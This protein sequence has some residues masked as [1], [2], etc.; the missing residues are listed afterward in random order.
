MARYNTKAQ[1]AF[2]Q[3]VRLAIVRVDPSGYRAHT[4][5]GIIRIDTATKEVVGMLKMTRHSARRSRGPEADGWEDGLKRGR[6][7][8]CGSKA[9]ALRLAKQQA[10]ELSLA[11]NPE[12]DVYTYDDFFKAAPI[13]CVVC[14]K[15]VGYAHKV[16]PVPNALCE[17]CEADATFGKARRAELEQVDV[18]YRN[19]VPMTVGLMDR[20]REDIGGRIL[21]S[22]ECLILS[23]RLST[24]DTHNKR[25]EH[26]VRADRGGGVTGRVVL[27]SQV[28]RE[29]LQRM[30]DTLSEVVEAAYRSGVEHGRSLLERLAQGGVRELN[31]LSTK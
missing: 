25:A 13:H 6:G 20:Y 28:Q 2:Y 1:E 3:P 21:A 16:G 29:A 12:T 22:L 24:R 18:M 5:Y 7:C 26:H 31:E 30:I 23:A 4:A 10:Q 9:H 27:M 19:L 15:H 8:T 11:F 17:T 14:G